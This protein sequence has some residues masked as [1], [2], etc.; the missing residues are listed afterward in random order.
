MLFFSFG[1]ISSFSIFCS[2]SFFL[3]GGDGRMGMRVF[4]LAGVSEALDVSGT[5]LESILSGE[6]FTFFC[7]GNFVA[8]FSLIFPFSRFCLSMPF[9]TLLLGSVGNQLYDFQLLCSDDPDRWC[10]TTGA[11]LAV[12]ID[13]K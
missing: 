2:D 10:G 13:A 11:C 7:Q 8:F 4:V 3:S 5:R 6:G 12:V 1:W 9:G